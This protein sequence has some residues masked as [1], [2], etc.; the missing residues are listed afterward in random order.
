MKIFVASTGRCGTRHI[1]EVF[2][3][4]TGI[5]SFHEPLPWLIGP[6]CEAVNNRPI[7]DYF[8]YPQPIF[9]RLRA[10]LVEVEKYSL[11]GWYFE[12]S[13][14]F[15]KSFAD[16]A[17]E[18][19]SGEVACIYLYRNPTGVLR[20]YRNKFAGKLYKPDWFLRPHWSSNVL[21]SAEDKS[22][23]E[24]VLWQCL[25]IRERYL[26]LRKKFAAVYEM[27]FDNLGSV[28]E[29]KRMFSALGVR[30]LPFEMMPT[31][32]ERNE[33]RAG[34]SEVRDW[35]EGFRAMPEREDDGGPGFVHID[36]ADKITAMAR[37]KRNLA[38]IEA[39]NTEAVTA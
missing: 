24:T 16:F 38:A 1:A 5:P 22:F 21:K 12:S 37:A 17:L 4:L 20:S 13:Q 9:E 19:W 36:F 28:W 15:V 7:R 33:S 29:W 35:C 32:L 11:D 25:E 39:R 10:K 3:A 27:D 18:S 26:R 6:T 8:V 2:G 30:H 34:A 14:I 23:D 31:G